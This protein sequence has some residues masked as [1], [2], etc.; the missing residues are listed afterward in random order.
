MTPNT[1]CLVETGSRTGIFEG[2]IDLQANAYLG[3]P[4]LSTGT[5]AGPPP[6][7]DTIHATYGSV[8]ASAGLVASI[9]E[10]LDDWD[11]PSSTFVA[12]HTVRL[13]IHDQ[14]RNNSQS[15]DSFTVT[16]ISQSTSIAPPSRWPRRA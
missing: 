12:G 7:R 11:R 5:T 14:I 1:W 16:V 8:T 10:F 15:R 2:Q 9:I 6:A 13:R 3:W 4:T